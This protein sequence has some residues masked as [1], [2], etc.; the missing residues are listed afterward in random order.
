MA[1]ATPH[2][3]TS[4]RRSPEAVTAAGELLTMEQAIEQLKTTRPTFYRWL[5]SGRIKGVKLGRQWRFR[6]DDLARLL[7]GE[8]PRIDLTASPQPLMAEL[9]QRLRA[10]GFDPAQDDAD[11]AAGQPI[12]GIIGRALQLACALGASDI[13]IQ[14]QRADAPALIRFR[15]SGVLHHP[16]AFDRRL[17]AAI[18]ERFKAMCHC[19]LHETRRPQDGRM[20][21]TFQDA[22]VDI[23]ACFVPAIGGESVTVRLLRREALVFR[24]DRLAYGRADQQRIVE[25]LARPSG[26]SIFTGPTGSGKTTSMYAALQHMNRPELKVMS[27]EDP[28]EYQFDGVAQLAVNHALG[29]SFAHLVRTVLRSDCNVLMIGEIRDLETLQLAIQASL[30]GQRVIT[31][32]HTEDAVSALQRMLD[33]GLSAFLV[34]DAVRAVVGQRLI[35]VL[36]NDCKAP[37]TPMASDLAQ[38]MALASA[39]GVKPEEL[40][41]SFHR[42]VGCPKCGHT[43]FRGRSLIAETLVMTPELAAAL[44]R[45]ATP[46]ELRG[47]A[48]GQG[49]TTMHADGI[50]RAASGQTTLEEV[51]SAYPPK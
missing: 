7:A 14:S 20:M 1:K 41:N 16:I 8:A 30:T 42:A 50:R 36:C 43:G 17:L 10:V 37:A 27:V 24:L 13:H 4:G 29:V 45:R 6:P 12:D 34:A 47:I 2:S 9:E 49:M 33:M 25:A 51:Y 44:R 26:I 28:V 46:E 18:V 31:C 40:P 5:R 32:L 19:D 3:R 23:R 35:R 39:G 38:A 48:I 11:I 21:F 15:V 22:P